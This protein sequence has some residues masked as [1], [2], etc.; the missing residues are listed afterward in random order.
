MKIWNPCSFEWFFQE[1]TGALSVS[2]PIIKAKAN[3]LL[4]WKD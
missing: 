4:V 2:G 1:R 3:Y